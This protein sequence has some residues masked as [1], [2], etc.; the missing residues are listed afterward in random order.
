MDTPAVQPPD[1]L[2]SNFDN[3]PSMHEL[4]LGFTI[5]CACITVAC[6]GIRTYTKAVILRAFK[7]EDCKRQICCVRMLTQ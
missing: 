1:G 4:V 5:A 3:P 7:H 2:H 6:I